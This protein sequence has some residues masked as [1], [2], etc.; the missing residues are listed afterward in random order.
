MYANLPLP[1]PNKTLALFQ[2]EGERFPN[3]L[4][5]VSV[6]VSL[7]QRALRQSR[8]IERCQR[9]TTR[10]PPAEMRGFPPHRQQLHKAGS[11]AAPPHPGRARCAGRGQ[12]PIAARGLLPRVA[13]FG[14]GR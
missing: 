3:G 6:K 13:G 14:W 8:L 1:P 4:S 7:R 9:L 2:A 10:A 5:F 11:S 12:H